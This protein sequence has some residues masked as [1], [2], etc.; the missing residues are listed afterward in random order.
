MPDSEL[1]IAA[2]GVVVRAGPKGPEVLVIHRQRYDDWTLPKG[3]SDADETPEA[4]ALREVAEETGVEARIVGS[5]SESQYPIEGGEKLVHWFSM[6]ASRSIGFEP[7]SEVD[8]VRWLRLEDAQAVLS[9][10][11]EKQVLSAFDARPA[12]T[13]GTLF[14]V[15]HGA[16]GNRSDWKKDDR[17]RPLS[18]R[19]ARQA[20]GL[21]S[22]LAIHPVERILTSPYIRC[23]QTVEPLAEKLGLEIEERGELGE[24]GSLKGARDLCL[25]LRGTNA[26]LCSHGDLIPALI[27][28]MARQGM[29]LKSPFDCKK[30]STWEV[31]VKA[32]E[33]RKAHYLPPPD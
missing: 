7:N 18:A 6:R 15:R 14:L 1:V 5:I 32:G 28:W 4:T 19:G 26:V 24:G 21:A 11:K 17:L 2:G 3:K 10:E 31:A 33:F 27:E 29:A 22:N 13:T 30:G 23:R 16:A 8:V 20:L 12:L 9:Y 25:K